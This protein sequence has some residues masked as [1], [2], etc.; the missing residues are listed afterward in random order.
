MLRV[1]GIYSGDDAE[2]YCH[3]VSFL[4]IATDINTSF[5]WRRL[6]DAALVLGLEWQAQL[7]RPQAQTAQQLP[8]GENTQACQL[9]QIHTSFP[10]ITLR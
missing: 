1:L 8:E 5:S 2:R 6:P 4:V 7:L 10:F 3:P 9:H